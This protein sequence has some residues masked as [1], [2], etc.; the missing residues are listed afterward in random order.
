[1]L[2]RFS[3]SRKAA[4]I[5]FSTMLPFAAMPAVVHAQDDPA[6]VSGDV[7]GYTEEEFQELARQAA[8]ELFD[9]D[10]PR[11]IVEDGDDLFI[12]YALEDGT[13]IGMPAS[14]THYQPRLSAG[15]AIKGPWVEYTPLE[16]RTLATGSLLAL[17]GTLCAFAPIG[18]SGC[19]LANTMAGVASAYI[20]ERGVCPNNQRLLVEYTW[21]GQ[22]RGA[23][24]R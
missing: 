20:G 7:S 15:V 13:R 17:S 19:V 6:S 24:C 10:L 14:L 11:E 23:Q 9:S 22:L 5:A 1:M 21:S 3:F 2:H 8:Q 12:V 16:Q 4:A 18:R